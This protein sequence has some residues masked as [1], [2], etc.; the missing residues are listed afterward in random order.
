M[1]NVIAL[2]AAAASVAY[3]IYVSYK[4]VDADGTWYNQLYVEK[5]RENVTFFDKLKH[6]ITEDGRS[7]SYVRVIAA[8]TL[9]PLSVYILTRVLIAG[10]LHF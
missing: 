9:L 10:V 5:G 2:F 6:A 1:K 4:T 7:I 8:F 3:M